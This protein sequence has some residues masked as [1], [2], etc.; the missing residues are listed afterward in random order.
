[1]EFK[2]NTL[3]HEIQAVDRVQHLKDGAFGVVIPFGGGCYAPYFG[4]EQ[5][6]PHETMYYSVKWDDGKPRPFSTLCHDIRVIERAQP[7]IYSSWSY[8][9]KDGGW[10]PPYWAYNA[11]RPLDPEVLA[12]LDRAFADAGVPLEDWD[13]EWYRT[14]IEP[15]PIPVIYEPFQDPR[16][17]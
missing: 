3:H 5:P 6:A 4:K 15:A 16:F 7:C 9:V 12:K 1:M 2:C 10:V 14:G 13:R 8:S 11:D 17:E